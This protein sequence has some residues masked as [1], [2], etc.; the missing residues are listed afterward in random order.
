MAIA[1]P[2]SIWANY[3]GIGSSSIEQTDCQFIS[4]MY[5]PVF[6]KVRRPWLWAI[7]LLSTTLLVGSIL[8]VAMNRRRSIQDDVADLTVQVTSQPLAVR[9]TASGTVQPIDS[10]NLS[11]RNSD[12]LMELY[13]EQG[14]AVT[15]GQI[16]A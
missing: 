5:V 16:I 10:V 15:Q 11:P 3:T 6:G 13:V 7:A 12:I 14:D 1:N 9:I 8:A 4:P 2:V